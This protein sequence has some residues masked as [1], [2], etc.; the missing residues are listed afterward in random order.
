[1]YVDP[2]DWVDV[3]AGAKREIRKYGGKIMTREAPFPC[4]F[5]CERPGDLVETAL[6]VVEEQWIEPLGAITADSLQREGFTDDYDSFRRYFG[7][8]YPAGFRPLAKVIVQRVRPMGDSAY[9][10][11]WLWERTYGAFA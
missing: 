3:T 4:V 10:R 11:D 7:A 5:Y 6:G 9:W 8:R 2:V 1:M